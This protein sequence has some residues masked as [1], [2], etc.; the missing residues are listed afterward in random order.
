MKSVTK[1]PARPIKPTRRNK[2]RSTCTAPWPN[3]HVGVF[4]MPE[5]AS[6][7][8]ASG[9]HV[10]STCSH[11]S[12][13][14]RSKKLAAQY[15]TALPTAPSLAFFKICF[16]FLV[17]FWHHCWDEWCA[18]INAN[19]GAQATHWCKAMLVHLQG[20]P[21]AVRTA[22]VPSGVI[23]PMVLSAKM[24]S[25]ANRMTAPT[26]I[27][28]CWLL[29]VAMLLRS[30]TT[31]KCSSILFSCALLVQCGWQTRG[32]VRSGCQDTCQS[33]AHNT[34]AR[35]VTRCLARWRP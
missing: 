10:T 1:R 22:K 6:K 3:A 23:Q 18:H 34:A 31:N 30:A 29:C 14:A 9:E 8:A 19:Q 35:A 16:F 5:C 21:W 11:A 25:H 13:K 26:C 7:L 17:F 28:V 20:Q 2:L 4:V 27:S 24:A 33:T 15:Q 32:Q 12:D